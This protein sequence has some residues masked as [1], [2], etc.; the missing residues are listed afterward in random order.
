MIIKIG[1]NRKA[2]IV[3]VNNTKSNNPWVKAAIARPLRI[4]L[5]FICGCENLA[6]PR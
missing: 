1:K 5:F 4:R 2:S 6:F 3:C